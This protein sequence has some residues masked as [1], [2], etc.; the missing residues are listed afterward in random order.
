MG[1]D[2]EDEDRD[3]LADFAKFQQKLTLCQVTPAQELPLQNVTTW[4]FSRSKAGPT[5]VGSLAP[6][7]SARLARKFLKAMPAALETRLARIAAGVTVAFF[8]SL[9]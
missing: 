1:G 4:F 8:P 9:N 6:W 7:R 3:E 5:A 2:L